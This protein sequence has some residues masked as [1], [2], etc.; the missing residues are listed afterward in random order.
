MIAEVERGSP[1]APPNSNPDLIIEAAEKSLAPIKA[2]E[3][4][5][6]TFDDAEWVVRLLNLLKQ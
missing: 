4:P 6:I 1:S 5:S 3:P 2:A